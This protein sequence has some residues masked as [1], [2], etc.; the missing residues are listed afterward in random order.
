[1]A[2]EHSSNHDSSS[3]P[4]TTLTN[5]VVT[6]AAIEVFFARS[7]AM[8][9]PRMAENNEAH[10]ALILEFLMTYQDAVVKAQQ[11]QRNQ[12]SHLE[13][14]GDLGGSRAQFEMQCYQHLTMS[15]TRMSRQDV[16]HAIGFWMNRTSPYNTENMEWQDGVRTCIIDGLDSTMDTVL[17]SLP[18]VP[19]PHCPRFL[20]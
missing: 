12:Y 6:I 10:A 15:L 17:D 3:N 8:E 19:E 4:R 16:M 9:N 14:I 5:S 2:T 20:L 1:M 13:A 18:V 11:H 7:D